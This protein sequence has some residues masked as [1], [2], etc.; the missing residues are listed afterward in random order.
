MAAF[1]RT[2]AHVYRTL[3]VSTSKKLN[4]IGGTIEH[5]TAASLSQIAEQNIVL[6]RIQAYTETDLQTSA[7]SVRSLHSIATSLSRIESL[8][9][10]AARTSASEKAFGPG[11]PR[12]TSWTGPNRFDSGY[13]SIARRSGSSQASR[14][15][16]NRMMKSSPSMPRIS[17][18]K[19]SLLQ[20]EKISEASWESKSQGSNPDETANLWSDEFEDT[21][22]IKPEPST[23]PDNAD[24]I[25]GHGPQIDPSLN[26]QY[27]F[28]HQLTQR[29]TAAI[30][31]PTVV[32]YINL[33]QTV[34]DYE[35]KISALNLLKFGSNIHEEAITKS[36][37]MPVQCDLYMLRHKRDALQDR[38]GILRNELQILRRRCITEGHMLHDID[39]R[40]GPSQLTDTPSMSEDWETYFSSVQ[41]PRQSPGEVLGFEDQRTNSKLLGKWSSHRDR[42]NR[43]LM[44]CLQTDH[45]QAQLHK[46]ML[47]DAPKNDTDWARQVLQHWYSDE[48]ATGGELQVSLSAG[49]VDSH[50]ADSS[51]MIPGVQGS[52]KTYQREGFDFDFF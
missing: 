4:S 41:V 8:A 52:V 23:L 6:E 45:T 11:S 25:L 10:S 7:A 19:L 50:T 34:K 1:S 40:F 43:W 14:R 16:S 39:Q 20:D 47:A 28:F 38:L 37:D 3:D 46:S 12:S 44:H 9:S 31:A 30:Y 51:R 27:H 26:E 18:T 5:G 42:V 15:V 21:E 22:C 49:A 17:N 35:N 2:H 33:I 29:L 48:A 13:Y 24:N 32:K 36:P